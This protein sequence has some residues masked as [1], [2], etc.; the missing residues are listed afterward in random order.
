MMEDHK[1]LFGA[2]LVV[3]NRMDTLLEREFN[4][5]NI[6]TKQWFL[7]IVIDN[8]FD[9]PPTIKEVA[10]EMG[11]SHQNVKQVALKLEKKGLLILE[12]D[13]RDSRATILRLTENSYNFWQNIRD[14]GTAFTKS[15]FKNIDKDD[16]V[17]ARK[18]IKNMLL[19]INEIDNKNESSEKYE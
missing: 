19:N 10:K 4:Q 15:L 14:E 1:Y 18:V 13:K 3:A 2:I 12:K 11:S 6:T 8:L 16:L 5:F 7:S 9:T 17:I